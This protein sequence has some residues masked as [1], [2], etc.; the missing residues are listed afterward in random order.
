MSSLARAVARGASAVPD[1]VADLAGSVL[2]DA[3]VACEASLAGFMGPTCEPCAGRL[4][5]ALVMRRCPSCSATASLDEA[6][7]P[8]SASPRRLLVHAPREHAGVARDLVIAL[9]ARRRVDVAEVLVQ[10]TLADPGV[11]RALRAAHVVVP[12]PGDPVRRRQRGVDHA[13]L[14]ASE[15]VRQARVMGL[16]VRALDALC[17]RAAGERQAAAG[18]RS[19]RL[20]QQGRLRLRW[21][22]GPFVRD[23]RVIVVDDVVTT[24][25][26]AREASAVLLDAGAA[27]V[28]VIACT[29]A[30]GV[31]VDLPARR[32]T[33]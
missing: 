32:G 19:R 16:R 33:P 22:R 30:E 27:A 2:E 3:C 1:L 5:T 9:K 25:A 20:R 24:G 13:A 4:A 12:V 11:L 17:F 8:C 21:L 14:L 10:A 18:A 7:L 26:T 15:I 6:C 23:R 28:E 29:R 31:I